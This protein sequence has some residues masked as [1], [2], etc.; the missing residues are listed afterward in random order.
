MLRINNFR[1]RAHNEHNN[2]KELLYKIFSGPQLATVH[3]NVRYFKRWPRSLFLYNE[4][5]FITYLGAVL[6]EY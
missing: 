5:D 1:Q 4:D 6:S 2:I 3:L